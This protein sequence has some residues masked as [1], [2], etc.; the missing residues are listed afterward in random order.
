MTILLFHPS[1]TIGLGSSSR[2]IKGTNYAVYEDIP[3]ELYDLRKAQV[4]KFKE[5]KSRGL[6][7]FF[8]KAQPDR[9]YISGKF[10]PANDPFF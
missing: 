7:V 3:K 4:S 1:K 5:A 2:T 8:S 9:L 10:I 6:K